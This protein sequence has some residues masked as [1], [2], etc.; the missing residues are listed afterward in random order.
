MLYLLPYMFNNKNLAMEFALKMPKV[1]DNYD[2]VG[3]SV[4]KSLNKI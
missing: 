4:S 1:Y 2:F 3:A